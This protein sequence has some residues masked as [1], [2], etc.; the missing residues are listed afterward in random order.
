MNIQIRPFNATDIDF[1][2]SL[3]PRFNEKTAEGL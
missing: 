2:E 3:I 1:I